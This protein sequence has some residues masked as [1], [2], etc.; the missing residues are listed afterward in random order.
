MSIGARQLTKETDIVVT[1][2]GNSSFNEVQIHPSET[3]L[4]KKKFCLIL[5]MLL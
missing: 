1:K 3:K 5:E 4:V 2:T